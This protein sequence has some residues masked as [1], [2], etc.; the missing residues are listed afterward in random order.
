M[1]AII[2]ASRARKDYENW[3]AGDKKTFRKIIKQYYF[4]NLL[5]L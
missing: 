4:N 1:R 5:F 3:S 2:F